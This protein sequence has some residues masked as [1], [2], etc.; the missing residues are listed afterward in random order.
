MYDNMNKKVRAYGLDG[1][2]A[3][4]TGA[5]RGIGKAIAIM[6]ASEGADVVVNYHSSPDKASEAAMTV[7]LDGEESW[8]YPANVG[9]FNDVMRMK[10]NVEENF[11]KIDIL[12]NNAGI[13]MDG[14]FTKM[15]HKQWKSVIDV[16]LSGA[17]NCTRVFIDDLKESEQGRIINISSVVGETGN[18]GQVNYAA[19]KAGVIG[20]TRSLAREMVRYDVTVNAVAPGF[21][22]T[23]M[24]QN[25]PEK[26]Q[27]RII[28]TI[29]MG[30]FGEPEEIAEVVA[31]LA[32]SK[33]SYITGA[34]INVNGGF[35]I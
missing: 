30:R 7:E 18:L 20:F 1:K 9:D 5:S 12:V 13:N 33:A 25:I 3:L 14:F 2:K 31:F 21:I 8:V 32:S 27:E 4:V 34:V 6:L 26:V 22:S 15:D 16:N 10:K 19:S 24:V 23:D 28:K 17:F 35:Y 11:G 29:P